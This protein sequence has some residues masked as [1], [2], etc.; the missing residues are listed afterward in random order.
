MHKSK[1]MLK[2]EASKKIFCM[3]PSHPLFMS[4][5]A[6]L[7]PKIK[8]W[9]VSGLKLECL[10]PLYRLKIYR[11]QTYNH[12]IFRCSSEHGNKPG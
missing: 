2:N 11:L 8:P 10:P 7:K 1:V 6:G 3:I 12:L 5:L 9:N 4:Y